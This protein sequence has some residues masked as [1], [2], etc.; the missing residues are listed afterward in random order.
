M[1]YD[2]E[3]KHLMLKNIPIQVFTTN[4]DK[5]SVGAKQFIKET[6]RLT[7]IEA[8]RHRDRKTDTHTDLLE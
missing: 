7:D 2:H 4:K 8:T 6:D 5:L 1:Y 3:Q